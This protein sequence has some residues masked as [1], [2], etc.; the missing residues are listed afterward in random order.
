MFRDI[1]PGPLHGDVVQKDVNAAITTI[2]TKGTIQ[3]VDWCPIG[4]KV[5]N[6]N[7]PPTVVSG[8]DLATVQRAVSMLSNST[9][10][11]EA[12]ARLDLMYAK[13]AFVHW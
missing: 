11:A 4:F 8:G 9:A 6:N 10:I 5:S 3:F 7:Q 2:K 13:R 1:H 12:W